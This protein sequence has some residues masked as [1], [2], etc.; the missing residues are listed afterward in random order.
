MSS[1]SKNSAAQKN[2]NKAN[3]VAADESPRFLSLADGMENDEAR[4]LYESMPLEMIGNELHGLEKVARKVFV[5]KHKRNDDGSSVV[6]QSVI[7]KITAIG[8]LWCWWTD[9]V[10]SSEIAANLGIAHST[11]PSYL[12]KLRAYVARCGAHP[13]IMPDFHQAYHDRRARNSIA[14]SITDE[15]RA[16]YVDAL[17]KNGGNA[18]DA[19]RTIWPNAKTKRTLEK[20]TAAM[21]A[22]GITGKRRK[23]FIVDDAKKEAFAKAL[24]K[25]GGNAHAAV[26]AVWPNAT[27]QTTRRRIIIELK[28]QGVEIKTQKRTGKGKA[29]DVDT[30]R[31]LA[32]MMRDASVSIDEI[33]DF[34]GCKP[35]M[36]YQ[37]ISHIRHQYKY[38]EE[39]ILIP[40]RK[41]QKIMPDLQKRA[42]QRRQKKI[43]D[44]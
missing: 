42:R 11:L 6:K 18:L 35:S 28:E 4:R 30:A 2:N 43:V 23:R 14:N 40:R 9:D 34:L 7:D 10:P 15:Q 17:A 3:N 8:S 41:R 19:A 33:A 21:K 20:Y 38:G 22:Q 24:A 13:A 1:K 26:K 37:H 5:F 39:I 12:A 36:V 29:V 16:A 27:A 44:G 25:N 32:V 31:R